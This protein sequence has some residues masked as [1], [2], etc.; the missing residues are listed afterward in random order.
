M[1]KQFVELV[2]LTNMTMIPILLDQSMYN[3]LTDLFPCNTRMTSVNM[4]M[5]Q[6][7]LEPVNVQAICRTYF[8]DQHDD[9]TNFIG[10]V[11]VQSTRRTSF[12]S[13]FCTSVKMMSGQE[14]DTNF[15]GPVNVD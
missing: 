3:Q 10:P 8:L 6:I 15:I 12:S 2:F 9:D 4:K 1:Y 5:I 11:N 14:Q 7:L 13:F